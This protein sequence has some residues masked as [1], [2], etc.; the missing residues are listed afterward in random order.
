MPSPATMFQRR[1]RAPKMAFS[2]AILMSA[3]SAFSSPAATAQPLTA[4]ITG[5][6]TSARLL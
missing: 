4:A 2:D 5:L 1:S 6:N 3:S